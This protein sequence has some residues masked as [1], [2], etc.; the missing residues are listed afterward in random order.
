MGGWMKYRLLSWLCCPECRSDDL[1]LETVKTAVVPILS[2]Q[3]ESGE[4]P[5]G[6][7]L[8]RLEEQVVLSGAIHCGDCASVY[9]IRDGVPRMMPKG[10]REGPPS[11][12]AETILDIARPEWEMNFQELMAPIK[13][14]EFLGK[15]VLDAG[16]GFGRHAFFAARYGAEVVCLDS[17]PDAVN[18]AQ[19]NLGGLARAHVIQGCIHT[20]PFRDELFDLTYCLGVLHHLEDPKGAFR[21]L[22]ATVRPGGRLSLFVYGPRQGLTLTASNVL[23]SATKEMSTDQLMQ[24]SG[25][26]ARG[27]RLFSHTPYRALRHLPLAQDVVSHLPVHDHHQWAFEVV[28]ADVYDRLRVPVHH[29]FTGEELEGLLTDDG[30]VDVQVTRRVRNNETFR[31][32]GI[33]R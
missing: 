22:G 20:P 10:A 16:C 15:L 9:P 6:V 14:G 21:N 23:R 13:P 7:D 19:R 12:H 25:V 1:R 17:S 33:R 11:P 28:V 24:F 5:A 8:D 29:W 26:V 31:A 3:F 30:Y 2:C 4:D 27:L 18:A 32:T